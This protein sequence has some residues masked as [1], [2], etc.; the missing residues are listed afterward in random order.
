MGVDPERIDAM[1]AALRTELARLVSRPPSE[2]E[3]E[4]AKRHLLG[5]DLSAAQSNEEIA[6]QLARQWVETGGLRSHEALAELLAQITASD[7]A[8]VA[9]AFVRGTI[10]RVDVGPAN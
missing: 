7:V 5:R 10:L 9:P 2:A 3:V 8:A 1:E 6:A 4:A